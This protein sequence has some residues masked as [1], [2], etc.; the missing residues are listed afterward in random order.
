M[1]RS[2]T[3]GDKM[4]SRLFSCGCHHLH[5]HHHQSKPLVRLGL[6]EAGRLSLATPSAAVVAPGELS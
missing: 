5:H 4:D 6:A 1:R 2:S 3:Q